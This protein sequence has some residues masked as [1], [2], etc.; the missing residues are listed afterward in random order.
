MVLH[1]VRVCCVQRLLAS[2]RCCVLLVALDVRI[3][4]DNLLCLFW[5]QMQ[6]VPHISH[7][8][9]NVEKYV[10]MRPHQEVVF[11]MAVVP[12]RTLEVAVAEYWSMQA[13]CAASLRIQFRGIQP[14]S[15]NLHLDGNEGVV[16]SDIQAALQDTVVAPKASLTH[17]LRTLQPL[18]RVISSPCH[19]MA[20]HAVSWGVVSCRGVLCRAVPWRAGVVSLT[21]WVWIYRPRTHEH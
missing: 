18:V 21:I 15:R 4:I 5:R 20:C 2:C 7:K 17:H 16:R 11:S 13:S 1:M 12:G 9:T 10:R 8:H 14:L 19:V 3:G 6:L